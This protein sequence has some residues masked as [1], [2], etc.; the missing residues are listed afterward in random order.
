M[1]WKYEAWGGDTRHT[2]HAGPWYEWVALTNNP[3]QQVRYKKYLENREQGGADTSPSSDFVNA[4]SSIKVP[5]TSQ[6]TVPGFSKQFS[7]ISLVSLL[8]YLSEP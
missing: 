8:L 6:I 5:G 4:A 3:V 1:K 7:A 2:R